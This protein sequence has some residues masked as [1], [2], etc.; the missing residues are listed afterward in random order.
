MRESKD[1]GEEGKGIQM[2]HIFIAV[3]VVL[4]LMVYMAVGMLTR[5]LSVVS[6][7]HFK[8]INRMIFRIL[9]PLTLFF[10]IYDADTGQEIT[11]GVFAFVFICILLQFA[12]A[13]IIFAHTVKDTADSLTLAQ[14]IYRS[15][16]VL[17][18]SVVAGA[19]CDAGGLA[20]VA[21]LSILV[22]PLY[23][24]LAV[25][26]FEVRRCGEVHVLP[27]LVNIF[28]NPLVDAGILGCVCK[29]FQI[30]VPALIAQPLTTLGGIA[31]PLALVALGG[32]LSRG[33]VV[34]H[35]KYLIT[36]AVGKLVI[37]PVLVI[38]SAAA[39]GFRGNEMVAILAVFASPTAVASTP[40][41]QAM[42]G[43]GELAGEIVA[44]TSVFSMATIFLFVFFLSGAGMI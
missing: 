18:G 15:N 7:D 29:A 37:V 38:L 17:L 44:V 25:I 14:G 5:R 35:G 3:E 40:M 42:G 11:P 27:L 28:K 12:G 22:V 33:S 41:A 32:M 24:I 8:V 9:M 31:S 4:P 39:L 2:E 34:K 19:L 23:N 26:M 36:A 10:N 16:F 21:T 6:G 20:L 1:T 30:P 43:N 13:W